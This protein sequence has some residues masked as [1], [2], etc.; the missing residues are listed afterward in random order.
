MNKEIVPADQIA[1]RIRNFRGEKVLLDFDLAALYGVETRVLNQAVKRNADRFPSDFMFQLSVEETEM[2]SQRVTSSMGQTVSDSSQIVMSPGKHRGKRYRPYAFTE[3]GVAML[4]SVLN[5]ERAI[6]VNIAIM[7][8][9]VKLRQILE[10]NRELAK[11][12]SELEQR[13]GKH[14]EE[15]DAILEAIRQLM[16]PPDRPRRE[17]GFHVREKAPRYRARKRA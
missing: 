16:A 2:I 13:V 12:F 9:F 7:R 3:Q 1:S 10:T 8:A 15:I 4:S 14:D 17:I 5:S 6:K 11:K